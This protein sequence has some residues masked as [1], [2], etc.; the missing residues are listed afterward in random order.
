MAVRR[1]AALQEGAGLQAQTW[2]PQQTGTG[3]ECGVRESGWLPNGDKGG[4]PLLLQMHALG[5]A[6]H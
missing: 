2:S 4:G 1:Q 6:E 5:K 3:P